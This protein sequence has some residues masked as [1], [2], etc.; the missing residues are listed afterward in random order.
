MFRRKLKETGGTPKTMMERPFWRFFGA[1]GDFFILTVYW[2]IGSLPIVTIGCS[3]TALFYV[4]LKKRRNEESTMWKMFKKSYK[5]NLKQGIFLWL[6]YVFIVLDVRI[7]GY[8]L[9][10]SGSCTL[11]DFQSGG[12]YYVAL[13]VAELI[14]LSVMLYSAALLALFKQTTGQLIVA[15]IGLAFNQLPS[16]ILF[17]IILAAIWFVMF[18]LFP[19]LVFVAIPMAVYLI[20]I[21]MNSIFDRQIRRAAEREGTNE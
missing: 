8:M 2:L 9:I 13:V 16:T 3:T 14:Y 5:E 12:R 19:A 15:S 1:L 4:C 10:Q 18:Y 20:S 17:L 21:R 7:I 6:L 11:A